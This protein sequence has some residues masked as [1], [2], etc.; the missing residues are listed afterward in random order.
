[1]FCTN[2]CGNWIPFC[3][4]INS[5]NATKRCSLPLSLWA[6]PLWVVLG[7]RVLHCLYI[8]SSIIAQVHPSPTSRL[9]AAQEQWCSKKFY[10]MNTFFP[11]VKS[12][13]LDQKCA[14]NNYSWLR[15]TED[16]RYGRPCRHTPANIMLSNC[17]QGVATLITSLPLRRVCQYPFIKV[18]SLLLTFSF[19]LFQLVIAISKLYNGHNQSSSDI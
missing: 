2:H 15:C 10:M 9:P 13:G 8:I 18:S 16:D 17:M 12:G 6:V 14:A 7:E 5:Y 4:Q 1:M 3:W 11:E 19:G